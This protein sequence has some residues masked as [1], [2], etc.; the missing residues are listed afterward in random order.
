MSP[1]VRRASDKIK[2]R[3]RTLLVL[4][5]SVSIAG[6]MVSLLGDSGLPSALQNYLHTRA[7][8]AIPPQASLVVALLGLLTAITAT[9]G[10][11]LFW[12]PARL[13][14]LTLWAVG[15]LFTPFLGPTVELGWTTA[16][17][18]LSAALAGL[19]VGL[20]FCSP[21]KDLFEDRN[22]STPPPQKS[23]AEPEHI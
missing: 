22:H 19:I 21:V 15:F 9:V 13:L 12:K 17:D 3:F 6:G 20:C 16:L 10:L 18:E 7:H 2:S 4:T 8:A 5:T 23:P 11:F 1:P 14:W